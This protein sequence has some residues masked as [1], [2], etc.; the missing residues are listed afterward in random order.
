MNIQIYIG[1]IIDSDSVYFDIFLM[2]YK[3]LKFCVMIYQYSGFR[4][5][6]FKYDN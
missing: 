5:F 2:I 6:I 4:K 3:G 1:S